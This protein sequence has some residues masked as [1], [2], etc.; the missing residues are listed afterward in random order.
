MIAATISAAI[1]SPSMKAGTDGDQAGENGQ[2]AGHVTGEMESIGAQRGGLVSGRAAQR[3]EHAA[4]V[5]RQRDADDGEHVP[6]RLKRRSAA[7]QPSDRR[8]DHDDPAAEQD[9]GLAE[10][11]RGSPRGGVRMGGSSSA[12][13][14]PSRMANSVSTAA[15]TSPLDSIPA[16]T[17]PRLPVSK[18]LPSFSTTSTVA[19][20]TDTAAVRC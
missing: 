19:A 17:R 9:R 12:G 18:P 13:R 1:A 10:R 2:R 15:T 20:N 4:D 7:A 11:R 14:P 8:D 6:V 5:D 3:D 16:D